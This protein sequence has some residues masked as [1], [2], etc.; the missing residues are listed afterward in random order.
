MLRRQF[1]KTS[2]LAGSGI[3]ASASTFNSTSAQ[4]I[5]DG[6]AP[7]RIILSGYGPSTSSFSQ[8]LKRIG[9]RLE[10]RFGDEVDIKYV[11]NIMDLSYNTTDLSRLVDA[12]VLSLAY[13]TMSTGVP[14][15][16]VAALPFLFSDTATAR[17]A[18]DG[19]LGQSAIKSIEADSN[20]RVLGFFENGFRHVANNVRPVHTPGDMEGLVIRVLEIQSRAFELLGA[21]PTTTPLPRV[22][23]GLE[24]GELDGQEN[25]FENMVTY[26]LYR[27]QRY[28]TE[29]YHSYLS[30]PIY[31]HRPSFDAWPEGLQAEMRDAVQDAVIFQRQL[32]DQ[33]E[34][35]SAA[36]IREFG[37]EIVQLRSEQREAFIEAVAPIYTNLHDQYSRE[38]LATVGL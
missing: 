15:L 6:E 2:A 13:Q 4:Q 38:L 31:V 3:I 36:V 23:S 20:F 10:S 37:G 19:E 7:T 26:G 8:G 30:R 33:A 27:A 1:L 16:E 12:G 22:F 14:E 5:T 18:M 25:P 28:Y 9:D 21:S 32:H 24:S 11:Y 29:T 34:I 17:A 35:D